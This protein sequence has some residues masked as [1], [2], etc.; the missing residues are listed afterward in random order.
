M[1]RVTV[2]SAGASLLQHVL[3]EVDAP[4]RAVPLVAQQRVGGAGGEAE[5]A[6]NAGPQHFVGLGHRRVR[7]LLRGELG[8]HPR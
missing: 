6:V 8:L 5:P 3:D 7:E 1:W 4:A 2:A